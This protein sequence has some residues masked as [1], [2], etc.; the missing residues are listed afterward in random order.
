MDG[1]FTDLE[2]EK[3]FVEFV[4][5]CYQGVPGEITDVMWC[6]Q[7]IDENRL[8]Y[9]HA[10]YKQNIE[11]FALYLES[12]NPDHCKRAGALLHALYKSDISAFK[13]ESTAE[14]LDAG[15]TRI[16]VGDAKHV[17]PFLTFWEMYYNQ[18]LAFDVAY[19]CCAAYEK[20]PTEL[21]V[22]YF[23]NVCRYLKASNNLTIDDCYMLFKSLMQK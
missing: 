21:T 15:F 1:L 23:H 14:E 6:T 3:F 16:N 5:K 18:A 13:P 8:K 22:E 12:S 4:R 17:L 20:D 2:N 9:A 19:R 7:E 10:E 11:K